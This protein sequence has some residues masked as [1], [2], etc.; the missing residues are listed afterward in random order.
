MS[1]MAI[2]RQLPL[3]TGAQLHS[4]VSL[5]L[6]L[7]LPVGLQLYL[8]RPVL[9]LRHGGCRGYGEWFR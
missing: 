8:C 4:R 5:S 7:S 2:Y 6:S 3:V 1:D 9:L